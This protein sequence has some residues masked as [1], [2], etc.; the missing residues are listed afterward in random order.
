MSATAKDGSTPVQA[1]ISEKK[2]EAAGALVREC[3]AVL[4]YEEGAWLFEDL[5][6]F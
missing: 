4:S 1:A 2:K 3:G 5:L 6:N